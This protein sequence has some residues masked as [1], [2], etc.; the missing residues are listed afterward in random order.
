MLELSCEAYS[1]LARGHYL[2]ENLYSAIQESTRTVQRHLA[3]YSTKFMYNE[4]RQNTNL[5]Y[6]LYINLACS[7]VSM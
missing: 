1:V 5:Y 2:R 4:T 6:K 3:A 7:Y